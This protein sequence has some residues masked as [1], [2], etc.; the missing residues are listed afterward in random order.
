M[1][2]TMITR[3]GCRFFF[4]SWI[5]PDDELDGS[6]LELSIHYPNVNTWF[7]R[8]NNND[9]D[10][11]DR[12][13]HSGKDS[14][15]F[16]VVSAQQESIGRTV[17]WRRLR[18]VTFHH[19]SGIRIKYHLLQNLFLIDVALNKMWGSR[20]PSPTSPPYLLDLRGSHTQPS[21]CYWTLFSCREFRAIIYHQSFTFD[22]VIDGRRS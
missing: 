18:S 3:N 21:S 15:T 22:S 20:G 9:S 13:G 8:F 1:M 17:G 11:N 12:A 7:V 16:Q 5:D 6:I 14:R 4:F 2:M 19:F 10:M